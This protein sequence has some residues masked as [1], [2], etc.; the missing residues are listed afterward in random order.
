MIKTFCNLCDEELDNNASTVFL[1][2]REYAARIEVT[3]RPYP[4]SS[5]FAICRKCKIS[6]L[7]GLIVHLEGD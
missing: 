6:L 2:F 4:R 3:F 7:H 5:D 1:T